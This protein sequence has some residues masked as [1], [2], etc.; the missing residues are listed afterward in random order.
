MADGAKYEQFGRVFRVERLGEAGMWYG[1][2]RQRG[3][4]AYVLHKM[5]GEM[6]RAAMEAKLERWAR[7]QGARR[8]GGWGAAEE[9]AARVCGVRQM[10]FE[11]G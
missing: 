6:E 3:A 5:G 11:F 2:G 8:V 1:V 4:P 9:R 7:R 10:A